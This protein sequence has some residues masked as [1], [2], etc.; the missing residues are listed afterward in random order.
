MVLLRSYNGPNSAVAALTPFLTPSTGPA[1][2]LATALSQASTIALPSAG[3][4]PSYVPASLTASANPIP[5]AEGA[6]VGM[7]TITWNAPSVTY[8]EVRVGAPDGALFTENFNSDSAPTG[9]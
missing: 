7:T 1:F 4:P 5:V 6:F 8:I 9:L 3:G 2:S